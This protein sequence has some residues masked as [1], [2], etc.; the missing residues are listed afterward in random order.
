MTIDHPLLYTPLSVSIFC[1]YISKGY[2]K[3]KLG[4]NW[5]GWDVIGMVW[6]KLERKGWAKQDGKDFMGMRM[7]VARNGLK[8]VRM[9]WARL[10]SAGKDGW[11]K[12][13][14]NGLSMHMARAGLVW[15]I[16][17]WLVRMKRLGCGRMGKEGW[18]RSGWDRMGWDGMRWDGGWAREARDSWAE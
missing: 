6:L 10:D 16:S 1:S 17:A 13:D 14:G 7:M 18:S 5:I 9:G 2:A 11:V 12:Q 4:Q 8:W 3:T 15:M